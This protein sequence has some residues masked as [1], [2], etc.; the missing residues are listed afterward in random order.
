MQNY[1]DRPEVLRLIREKIKWV[2]GLDDVE[3]YKVL[4]QGGV[5]EAKRFNETDGYKKIMHA[6]NNSSD[7]RF[8]RAKPKSNQSN[9]DVYVL[10]KV[11]ASFSFTMNLVSSTFQVNINYDN[12]KA[13]K[14][15]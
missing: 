6:I 4:P 8:R 12:L 7:I 15:T 2:I 14:I 10:G 9:I 3:I 13:G 1:I 5:M 11:V